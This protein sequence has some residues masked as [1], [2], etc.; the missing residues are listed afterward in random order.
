[1]KFAE[2]MEKAVNELKT[3]DDLFCEMVDELDSW[4]GYADG[5]RAYDMSELDELHYG[6]KLTDFLA[7]L[8]KDF[9]LRDN[10]FYYSIWGLESTDDKTALYRDNADCGEV[11]DNIIEYRSHLYISDSDFEELLDEI[12]TARAEEN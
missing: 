12:E 4:N 7:R 1:M 9:D 8:T 11:L 5:F 10:Y 6:M 2:L 3:N